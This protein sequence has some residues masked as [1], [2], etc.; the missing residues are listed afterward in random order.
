MKYLVVLIVIATFV[1]S[2]IF[3]HFFF[4]EDISLH[5]CILGF[6]HLNCQVC[7]QGGS[8]VCTD[9]NDNGESKECPGETHVCLYSEVRKLTK[10]SYIVFLARKFKH[11]IMYSLQILEKKLTF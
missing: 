1:S 2:G 11:P 9:V 8:G 7:G 4:L 6:A 5:H 10:D 3:K